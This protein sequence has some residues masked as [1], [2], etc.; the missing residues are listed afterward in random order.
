MRRDPL[1][2]L[3]RHYAEQPRQGS[4]EFEAQIQAALEAE[5]AEMDFEPV[6]TAM[7]K[8]LPVAA[9]MVLG[10]LSTRASQSDV[11]RLAAQIE[12]TQ[13]SSISTELETRWDDLTTD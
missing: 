9:A 10:V 3:G 13:A 6:V 8:T 1:D 2:I 12:Q 11:S 7:R 4:S 5:C